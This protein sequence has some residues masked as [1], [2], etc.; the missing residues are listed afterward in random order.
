MCMPG[1]LRGG[2][3]DDAAIK[4]LHSKALSRGGCGCKRACRAAFVEWLHCSIVASLLAGDQAGA[5]LCGRGCLGRY[6]GRNRWPPSG[7][8]LPQAETALVLAACT[9]VLPP[10]STW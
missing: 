10:S 6:W 3:S 5:A 4:W 7:A 1:K 8:V 2:S 9:Q